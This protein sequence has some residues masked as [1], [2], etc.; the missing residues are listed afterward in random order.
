MDNFDKAILAAQS[1]I[2]RLRMEQRKEAE[3][4]AG[5]P[6]SLEASN[7]KFERMIG[8]FENQVKYYEKCKREYCPIEAAKRELHNKRLAERHRQHSVRINDF[9]GAGRDWSGD[10]RN[11]VLSTSGDSKKPTIYIN[12]QVSW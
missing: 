6:Y 9:T 1:N 2:D 4:L 3:R 5:Y 10:R 11:K 12:K 8:G 7:R